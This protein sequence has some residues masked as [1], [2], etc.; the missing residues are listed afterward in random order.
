MADE[1]REKA[2]PDISAL[3]E[4]ELDQEELDKVSGGFSQGEGDGLLTPG[5]SHHHH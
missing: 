4:K 1:D 5:P 2:D 3:E